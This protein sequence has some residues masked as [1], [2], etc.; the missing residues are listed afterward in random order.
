MGPIGYQTTFQ[1]HQLNKIQQNNS[2]ARCV[3]VAENHPPTDMSLFIDLRTQ[4]ISLFKYPCFGVCYLKGEGQDRGPRSKRLKRT[5]KERILLTNVPGE[6]ENIRVGCAVTFAP[7]LFPVFCAT[8]WLSIQQPCI[9]NE[10]QYI[11]D[12]RASRVTYFQEILI[13]MRKS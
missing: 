11:A 3:A 1:I 8:F 4:Y 5:G 9:L 7:W 12:V 6:V 2:P 13:H 10:M